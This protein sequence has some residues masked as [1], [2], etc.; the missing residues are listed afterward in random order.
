MGFAETAEILTKGST[1]VNKNIVWIFF[2]GFKFFMEN[3]RIHIWH[4]WS[5]FNPSFLPEDS[6][7]GKSNSRAG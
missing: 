4:F 6:R 2:E 7:N 5:N 1:L 3:G